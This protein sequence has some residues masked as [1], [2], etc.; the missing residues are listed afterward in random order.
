MSTTRTELPWTK[1]ESEVTLATIAT[2]KYNHGSKMYIASC[3]Y[4]AEHIDANKELYPIVVSGVTFK[5]IS[6]RCSMA[7]NKMG[8]VK[9]REGK[10]EIPWDGNGG[11]RKMT[12]NK[13]IPTKRNVIL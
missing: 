6:G 3:N 10:Y 7:M 8:W 5:G 1:I 2:A 12:V 13:T 11:I 4:I 9:W